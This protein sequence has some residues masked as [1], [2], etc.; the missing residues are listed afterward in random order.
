MLY[1]KKARS[2]IYD[3]LPLD[4][5]Q[6]QYGRKDE[7]TKSGFLPRR[8]SYF[9]FL[10]GLQRWKKTCEEKDA[11]SAMMKSME[12][13]GCKMARLLKVTTRHV[14]LKIV[15]F[16]GCSLSSQ[17]R[18][19]MAPA[20]QFRNQALSSAGMKI[21]CFSKKSFLKAAFP[22][23]R[24]Q[25]KEDSLSKAENKATALELDNE[26][27]KKEKVEAD[28]EAARLQAECEKVT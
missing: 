9:F 5:L 19:G 7:R 26:V 27:L 17:K 14:M 21:C 2:F 25:A 13:E 11:L 20:C 18:G 23:M 4:C 8:Y 15:S 6:M 1:S 12:K 22:L 28:K 10:F 24:F 3:E 16:P